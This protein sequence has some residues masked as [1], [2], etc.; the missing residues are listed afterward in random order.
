MNNGHLYLSARGGVAY[1]D[2][3]VHAWYDAI[4]QSILLLSFHTQ[5]L[6]KLPLD[7]S[8]DSMAAATATFSPP[9]N[10]TTL[11]DFRAA[12]TCKEHQISLWPH[13]MTPIL[14]VQLS[15]DGQYLAIQRSDIEVQILHCATCASYW[16]L[17]RSKVG[18]RILHGGVIWSA[19]SSKKKTT[20]HLFLVTKLGLEQYRISS[21]Q[22]C[23]ALFRYFG[24]S[25]HEFWYAASHG[26]LLVSS[27]L[28]A[29]AVVPFLL[30]GMNAEKFPE[31]VFSRSICKPDLNLVTLYGEMYVIYTDLRSM[32]LLVYLITR[33]N[34]TCVRSLNVLLP[35]ETALENS[36]VDNLLVCHSMEFNVSFFFDIKCE[37]ISSDPFSAPLPISLRPPGQVSVITAP[38]FTRW[39]FYASNLVQQSYLVNG[40]RHV[41]IRKLQL[42]LIE[43]C[44]T[45]EHHP[46]I[47][48]FL[49]RRGDSETA[50]LLVLKLARDYF[51]NHLASCSLVVRLLSTTFMSGSMRRDNVMK[52]GA[53]W[54]ESFADKD[55]MVGSLRRRSSALQALNAK[56]VLKIRQTDFYDYVWRDMIRD[57]SVVKHCYLSVFLIEYIK[58]LRQWEVPVEMI[59]CVALAEC[60]I[61]TEE[62]NK[63]YQFLHYHAL[64]DSIELAELMIQKG[65]T[66]PALIQVGLDMFFRLQE[67]RSMIRTFLSIGQTEQGLQF[68][69]KNMDLRSCVASIFPGVMFYD[70]LIRSVTSS[71]L[72]R[73]SLQVTQMLGSLLL[74]LKIWDP[75]SLRRSNT[76]SLSTLAT[77]ATNP[78]P[79]NLVLSSSRAKLRKAYG[80]AELKG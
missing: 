13:N 8:L 10:A 2:D 60:Y 23:C 73:S 77:S 38:G 36:V 6:Q 29:N 48:P 71:N 27:G 80:F 33:T 1:V 47:V 65:D 17:C 31:L 63:L 39:R 64:P 57:A 68:A 61:A 5:R 11:F 72:I 37:E 21:K 50:K 76:T 30:H 59:T 35:P 22:H 45:C 28:R 24:P 55:G 25:V 40:S 69:F 43:I 15:I 70:S 74:F 62:P 20:Q 44:K 3:S 46:D 58:N 7:A 14:F 16:V 51:L 52:L 34:T 9:K 32:K 26:L 78:F 41:E 56:S 49:L 12:D 66:Y 4:H 42:N 67:F 79:D 75:A 19:H 18:N 53:D 54:T